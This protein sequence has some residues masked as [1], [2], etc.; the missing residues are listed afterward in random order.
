MSGST[1]SAVS[2]QNPLHQSAK[3]EI[4]DFMRR[5]FAYAK[6]DNAAARAKAEI[7]LRNGT[8]TSVDLETALRRL[9]I[10]CLRPKSQATDIQATDIM[11]SEVK[12]E[13]LQSLHQDQV[14]RH[15]QTV[16]DLEQT[17]RAYEARCQTLELRLRAGVR[18]GG[19]L[20]AAKSRRLMKREKRAAHYDV[21]KG[22]GYERAMTVPDP[23]A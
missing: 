20:S 21:W 10:L 18:T 1:E 11:E 2:G 16:Q 12:N 9:D 7:S 19:S 23:D 6:K 8:L 4:D 17:L 13:A 3:A 22:A 14:R 5:F 15:A